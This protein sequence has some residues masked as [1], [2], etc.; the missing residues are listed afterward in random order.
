M[1]QTGANF[2]WIITDA[3]SANGIYNILVN[4]TERYE[5][6]NPDAWPTWTNNTPFSVS[7]NT[8]SPGNYN[9]TLIFGDN[10]D[11]FQANW[12]ADQAWAFIAYPPE[13]QT[14]LLMKIHNNE[15]N[16]FFNITI[17][18]PDTN[19]GTLNFSING[20]LTLGPNYSWNESETIQYLINT[21]SNGYFNYSVSVSDGTYPTARKDS[22]IWIA[23]DFP[24]EISQINDASVSSEI[25]Y[26]NLT[27]TITD[28][29]LTGNYSIFE[30]GHPLDS[31]VNLTWTNGTEISIL[32]NASKTGTY[33]YSIIAQDIH[34]NQSIENFSLMVNEAPEINTPE[35]ATYE[36]S[37]P[38]KFITWV[39]TDS[40]DLSGHFS[41]YRN[42][43][44]LTTYNNLIW[45]NNT[46]IN[47][48]VYT[49]VPGVYNYTINFTDG[50]TSRSQTTLITIQ[51]IDEPILDD[52]TVLTVLII[53]IIGGL[54]GMIVIL[55][56]K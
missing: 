43:S 53:F 6:L 13:I 51:G 33:N 36:R 38:G 2:T 11:P 3:D 30:S 28:E 9:Y 10:R 46:P 35:N 23:N 21:S 17:I 39:I 18:D 31:L 44:I 12:G 40:D 5:L 47:V 34:G 24:P 42:G 16:H 29:N 56:K 19:N 26:Y 48:T 4:G 49:S 41:V 32:L 37:E 7:I 1:N 14:P 54:I 45:Y 27:F 25:Q 8:S 52:A 22:I 55:T 20:T 15:S 50:L